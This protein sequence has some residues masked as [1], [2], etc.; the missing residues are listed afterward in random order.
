MAT[1]AIVP[2]S[3]DPITKGHVN[4]I[5]RASAMFDVVYAVA[6]INAEKKSFYNTDEKLEIMKSALSHLGN[7]KCAAYEGL[8]S[9]F[10]DE[11]SANFVVRGARNPSDFDAEYSYFDIIRHFK[12]DLDFVL[13]PALPSLA[14]IS[15]TYARELIRHNCDLQDIADEKTAALMTQFYKAK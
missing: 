4:I 5:E 7:V 2:G 14:Y 12:P 8:L 10:A 11:V 3:F 1:V 15:S 9:D 6:V 13:I